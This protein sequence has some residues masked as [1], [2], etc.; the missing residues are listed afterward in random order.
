M[1]ISRW[2]NFASTKTLN[3]FG[4]KIFTPAW[5][6]TPNP[7]LPSNACWKWW[8]VTCFLR[9][10]VQKKWEKPIHFLSSFA[11]VYFAS[12]LPNIPIH[13]RPNNSFC[14]M[15]S[16]KMN[17]GHTLLTFLLLDIPIQN[18]QP[19]LKFNRADGGRITKFETG[20][21]SAITNNNP[22]PFLSSRHLLRQLFLAKVTYPYQL[23]RLFSASKLCK[24]KHW[25]F[26]HVKFLKK[27][28][29]CVFTVSQKLVRRIHHSCL[30]SLIR[31]NILWNFR[32]WRSTILG[33]ATRWRETSL[34]SFE[35]R[36]YQRNCLCKIE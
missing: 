7:F 18:E 26:Q 3:S 5:W 34:E 8:S 1:A 23:D 2:W 12:S 29:F 35:S 6:I 27:T 30:C 22:K 10:R 14:W 24:T 36:N 33:W 17:N 32:I 4:Q 16:Q 25:P 11:Y 9:M 19:K 20:V 15:W 31:Y 21:Y 13:N 28:N